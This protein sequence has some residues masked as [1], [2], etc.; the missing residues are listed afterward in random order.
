MLLAAGAPVNACSRQ[1]R[2]P[3]HEACLAGFTEFA[4]VL[5]QAGADPEIRDENECTALY[6]AAGAG[7]VGVV[8]E[9]LKR[10]PSLECRDNGGV[11]PLLGACFQGQVDVVSLLS[12]AGADVNVLVD[13]GITQVTPLTFACVKKDLAM[14]AALLED[15]A[16][17]RKLAP[18][19]MADGEELVSMLLEAGADP[20]E[21]SY[22]GRTPLTNACGGG[23]L[24]AVQRLLDAGAAANCPD[25]AG[26]TPLAMASAQGNEHIVRLLLAAGA[27]VNRVSKGRSRFYGRLRVPSEE[28]NES[29]YETV[30]D[31]AEDTVVAL[32]VAAAKGHHQVIEVLVE[33]GALSTI[34]D[35]GGVLPI[36]L[37]EEV[38]NLQAVLSLVATGRASRRPMDRML[39]AAR[40]QRSSISR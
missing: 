7:R 10:K 35:G 30:L 4:F 11:T 40:H 27:D 19:A 1:N 22:H 2:T 33:H 18:L 24:A 29:G 20:N 13:D 21:S 36:T 34:P 5:L 14:V 23:E 38:G 25:R 8:K 28:D 17:P 6:L 12:W 26:V 32:G 16:N 15:G 9:L 39:A 37:A 31:E 3:L